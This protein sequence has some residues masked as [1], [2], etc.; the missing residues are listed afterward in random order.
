MIQITIHAKERLAFRLKCN[1]AKFNR[2]AMKAW[3][4][5]EPNS[6]RK[7]KFLKY[8]AQFDENRK[9]IRFRELMGYVFI[10]SDDGS[11]V[12]LITLY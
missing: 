3:V 9:H 4:A 10:F 6:A 5:P 11:R 7:A 12:K 2:V 8:Q 1:P